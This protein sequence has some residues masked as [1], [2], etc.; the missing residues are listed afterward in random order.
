MLRATCTKGTS[1]GSSIQEAF[2]L[3]TGAA[4]T[5]NNGIAIYTVWRSCQINDGSVAIR[6]QERD[7]SHCDAHKGSRQS[8]MSINARNAYARLEPKELGG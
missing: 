7:T 1:I 8:G 6:G 3:L 5:K 2:D 4:D